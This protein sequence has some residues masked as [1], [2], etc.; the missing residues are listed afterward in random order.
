M[1]NLIALIVF[2]AAVTAPM[3]VVTSRKPLVPNA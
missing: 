1:L 2:T 3:A